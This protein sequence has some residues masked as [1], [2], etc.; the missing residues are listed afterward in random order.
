M[1]K[2]LIFCM[3]GMAALPFTK[4]E[5]KEKKPNVLFI[6]VD[7]LRP[8]LNC[9]GASYM[10]TPNFDRLAS[11]GTIFQRAYCQQ[12]VSAA[13][14]NSLLTGLRPDAIGI[15]DLATYFRTSV[16]DVVT[17]PQYFK[18]NGYR[19]ERVGK[20]YHTGHGNKDD[21]LAW[22]VKGWNPDDIFGKLSPITSGD[23]VNMQSDGPAIAGKS[24]P[25]Y[26][27]NIPQ[28][29]MR[30]SR[31]VKVAIERMKELK[32][33]PFFLAVGLYRP[34]LPFVAPKKYWD[35]Y[36][37]KDIV[38]P[39]RKLPVGMPE[40]S[41]A[42][43]GELRKY[44]GMP[45][46][47]SIN[48]YDTKKLIHGYRACVSFVDNLLGQLLDALEAN[49]LA[50]NTI[51]V[52]WG[53]HGWKLGE[54]GQWCKHS[55]Q[56]FDTNAPLFVV[57]PGFKKGQKSTSLVEYVDV[58][59]TLCELANLPL[60]SHLQGKSLLPVLKNPQAK[61]K[62]VAISQYPRDKGGDNLMGYSMRTEQYRYTRWV[63]FKEPGKP[64]V[65]QE[66]YDQSKGKLVSKNLA[67]DPTY[68]DKV[69]ELD[70][71]LTI[72]LSKYKVIDKLPEIKP[73]AK[74]KKK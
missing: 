2:D 5:G 49:G 53:D 36:D 56:E 19:T 74:P 27:T 16:P 70:E 21:E 10:Q 54:Y 4:A 63:K 60:P 65:S 43:F 20:I 59:P 48:D 35:L 29:D 13:T 32:D 68:Q 50:D 7:D 28:E 66:L 41:M 1:K 61:I 47:G 17:L 40:E 45:A 24:L 3:I 12:A 62:D 30:D 52:L 15:Y 11:Q 26:S 6:A 37:E 42:N 73:K 69:K 67:L 51:I 8:E 64:I 39:K 18:E 38:I 57:A 33:N 34:H 71:L 55:N 44:H 31:S 25:Y 46:K 22:S 58:Y 23:T 9:F 72:E 14:R